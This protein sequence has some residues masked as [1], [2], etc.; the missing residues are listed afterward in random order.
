[1]AGCYNN[2]N[3]LLFVSLSALLFISSTEWDAY[4]L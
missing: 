4:P 3:G 1:M 2:V